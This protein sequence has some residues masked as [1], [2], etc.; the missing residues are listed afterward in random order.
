MMSEPQHACP[1]ETAEGD[2]RDQIS[3]L[4]ARIEDLAGVIESCRK[5]ILIS[6]VAIVAGGVSLLAITLGV[7]TFDPVALMGATAAVMGGI[8]V[9]GSNT[10]TAKQAAANIKAAEALRTELIGKINLRPV[11]EA[12][13]PR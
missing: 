13:D 2:P 1:S 4:E 7:I 12:S 3:R 8:V 11:G 5:L 9:F 10:S 6:R